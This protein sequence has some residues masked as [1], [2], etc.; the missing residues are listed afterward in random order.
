MSTLHHYHHTLRQLAILAENMSEEEYPGETWS[1]TPHGVQISSLARLQ[2]DYSS[3]PLLTSTMT[4]KD[5][6]YIAGF[7]DGDGNI[8]LLHRHGARVSIGQGEKKKELL[9]YVLATTGTGQVILANK[10]K[11][12]HNQDSYHWYCQGEDAVRFIREIRPYIIEKRA[13]ADI[14]AAYHCGNSQKQGIIMHGTFESHG[15]AAKALDIGQPSF[16]RMIRQG[17]HVIKKRKVEV[18]AAAVN[19]KENHE[20]LLQAYE[21]TKDVFPTYTG[22]SFPIKAGELPQDF[23]VR[24]DIHYIAGFVEAEGFFC[25]QQ[26]GSGYRVL[27]GVGQRIP[28]VLL[29]LMQY[30]MI[31]KIYHGTTL[32]NGERHDNFQWILFNDQAFT[33]MRAIR[34]YVK[35]N[36]I[37]SQIDLIL[38][39]GATLEVKNKLKKYKGCTLRMEHNPRV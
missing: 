13:H 39:G 7:L 6:S 3:Q 30:F 37:M 12:V 33:Y 36:A 22:L 31:G 24:V 18:V 4:R 8:T 2:L 16:S 38:D 32:Y 5:C 34:P 19:I 9:D 23:P 1:A 35:S 20:T 11:A 17:K 26:N 10:K 21:F 14:L 29:Q 27:C 28:Y 25:V 15:K